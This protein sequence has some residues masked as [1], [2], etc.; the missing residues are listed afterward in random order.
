MRP[1]DVLAEAAMRALLAGLLVDDG[2]VVRE[3]RLGARGE[4]EGRR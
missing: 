2:S 4:R 3:R 1:F